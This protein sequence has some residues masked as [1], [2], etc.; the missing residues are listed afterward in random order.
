MIVPADLPPRRRPR[1]SLVVALVVLGCWVACFRFPVVWDSTGIGESTRPF[2]D[3]YGLIASSDAARAGADPY[4]PNAL[5]PYHRPLLYTEWWLAAGKLGLTRTDAIWIGWTWVGATLVAALA[6]MRPR[7]RRECTWA[8][9]WLVVKLWP[10]W[11]MWRWSMILAV[12]L[13]AD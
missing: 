9:L 5:D 2:L 7:T 13:W 1:A 12:L 11:G 8:F 3:L 10:R 6:V 4:Q